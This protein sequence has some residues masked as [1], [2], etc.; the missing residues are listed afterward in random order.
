VFGKINEITIRVG[1]VW[2]LVTFIVVD[3][4]N[5]D[6]FLGLA[7]LIKIEIVIDVEKGTIQM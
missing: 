4:D 2:C 1:E 5:Y 6:L 3:I 7:F